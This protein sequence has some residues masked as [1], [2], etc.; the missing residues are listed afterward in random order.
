MIAAGICASASSAS[1]VRATVSGGFVSRVQYHH[2]RFG[3]VV[4]NECIL[5]TVR[6]D[7]VETPTG[8]VELLTPTEFA[9]RT[10]DTYRIGKIAEGGVLINHLALGNDIGAV[11]EGQAEPAFE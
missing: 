9:K 7:L 1:S 8:A 11:R 4:A 10:A 2:Q 5:L 3:G 6:I